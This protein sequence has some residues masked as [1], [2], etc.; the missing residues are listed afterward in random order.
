MTRTRGTDEE[1]APRLRGRTQVYLTPG[2][3]VRPL[4]RTTTRLG[5]QLP[6]TNARAFD[7]AILGGLV[8]EF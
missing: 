7:Y 6:V 2:F 1:D 5:V 3:N 8:R 4:P